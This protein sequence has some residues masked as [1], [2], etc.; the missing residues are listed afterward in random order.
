[1]EDLSQL[2]GKQVFQGDHLRLHEFPQFL[3]ILLCMK[4]GLFVSVCY[5]K[6]S[7]EIFYLIDLTFQAQILYFLTFFGL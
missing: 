5:S 2:N 6:S 4:N 7:R 3:G 1:M